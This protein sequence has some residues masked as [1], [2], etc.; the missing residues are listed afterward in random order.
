MTIFA[1]RGR[2]KKVHTMYGKMIAYYM[3][4]Q[5][6][7]CVDLI[8]TGQHYQVLYIILKLAICF[9]FLMIDVSDLYLN[10]SM[11]MEKEFHSKEK[12]RY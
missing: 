5:L 6:P 9:E 8:K 10:M 12:R 7:S 11:R 1:A 2:Y 3:S 4:G